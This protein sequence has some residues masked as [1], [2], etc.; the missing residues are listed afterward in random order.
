VDHPIEI[1]I[2]GRATTDVGGQH[3]PVSELAVDGS[4]SWLSHNLRWLDA[5]RHVTIRPLIRPG[6]VDLVALFGGREDVHPALANDSSIGVGYAPFSPLERAVR[7]A[8]ARLNEAATKERHPAIGEDVKVLGIRRGGRISLTVA[9]AMIDRFMSGAP[10]YLDQKEQ[11]ARLAREAAEEA[12]GC[13]VSVVV[14]TAD[15]PKRERF[16]LTVTG[17]S[18]EAGDDGQ[19]GRGNRWNGMITPYR[20]MTLE[21]AAGKNAV[22]HVGKLYQIAAQRLA[23]A[24]VTEAA[25]VRAAEC[26]LA[27]QI[28]RPITEPAIVD[29]KLS[30][31]PGRDAVTY[32]AVVEDLAARELAAL[33]EAW[34]EAVGPI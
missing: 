1:L 33:S 26:W 17:T 4:R 21:S 2:A 24:L 25:D 6:S 18:A 3:V 20:P 8:E 7:A 19:A 23:E 5:D 10:D 22:S 31:P 14:N 34:R 13:P 16:Y 30:L 9:A 27:S 32:E 28:G 29:V 12:A 15:D 11:V